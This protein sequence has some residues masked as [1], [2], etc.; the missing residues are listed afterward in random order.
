MD[1]AREKTVAQ[2]IEE[3]DVEMTIGVEDER[4]FLSE[5]E[6]EDN[7]VDSGTNN[8]ATIGKELYSSSQSTEGS[9][10]AHN[11]DSQDNGSN[12]TGLCQCWTQYVRWKN[13]NW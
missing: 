13:R 1:R 4:E 2:L 11:C 7:Y 10:S 3:D 9:Q 6:D 8:N 12:T 5:E